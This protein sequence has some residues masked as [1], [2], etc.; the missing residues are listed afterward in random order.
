[1]VDTAPDA[2]EEL[3]A[4][5][6]DHGGTSEAGTCSRREIV[7]T[8]A[9]ESGEHGPIKVFTYAD[10]DGERQHKKITTMSELCERFEGTFSLAK[11]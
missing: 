2:A 5:C 7:A 6:A 3:T 8:C 11:H 1:L 9:V 10:E 4:D